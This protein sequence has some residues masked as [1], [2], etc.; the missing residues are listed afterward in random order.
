MIESTLNAFQFSFSIILE[1]IIYSATNSSLCNKYVIWVRTN[2][3]ICCNKYFVISG[4]WESPVCSSSSQIFVY[5][6]RQTLQLPSV[7]IRIIN[8]TK[9]IIIIKSLQYKSASSSVSLAMNILLG[10]S[11]IDHLYLSTEIW[12][13]L[14]LS[15][16]WTVSNIFKST[17]WIFWCF[18]RSSQG[19]LLIYIFNIFPH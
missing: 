6:C 11:R 8:S 3:C 19:K 14:L 1:L 13:L 16:I 5:T 9:T 17:A 15:E 7:S 12:V 2:I 10:F 18:G 4:S